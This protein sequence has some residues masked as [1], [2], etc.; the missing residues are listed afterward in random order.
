MSH[1]RKYQQLKW[2]CYYINS[3]G[4]WNKYNYGS[5]RMVLLYLEIDVVF[6]QVSNFFEI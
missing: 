4:E 6:W 5:S 2:E 3:K 1:R